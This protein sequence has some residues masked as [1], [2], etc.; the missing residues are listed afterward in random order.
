M[1]FSLK[2]VNLE[3]NHPTV[4]QG[5]LRLDRALAAARHER[6]ALLKL[7]HGYGSSGVGGQLRVEVW[8]VLDGYKRAGTIQ[9]FIPGEQFR[10]SD[11][12]AWALLKRFPE[13]KQDRDFGR[14]NRGITL[15]VP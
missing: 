9:E 15:V 2:L 14:G 12:K 7:I 10:I 5:L 8:K 11:E 4:N 6:V 13:L 1:S 3:E